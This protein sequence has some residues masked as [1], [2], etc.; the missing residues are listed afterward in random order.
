MQHVE[1]IGIILN[2]CC[3]SSIERGVVRYV[4]NHYSVIVVVVGV[5]VVVNPVVLKLGNKE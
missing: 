5:I 2:I 4:K 3:L 1:R